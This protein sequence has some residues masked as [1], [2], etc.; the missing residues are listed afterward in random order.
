MEENVH[1][2][3]QE[4]IRNLQTEIKNCKHAIS[5]IQKTCKHP[6]EE[7]TLIE[8]RG[9]KHLKVICSVCKKTLRYPDEDDLEKSD[10]RQ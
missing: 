4:K 8:E 2:N 6:K 9:T 10:Y 1:Q 7:I 5:E 3:I